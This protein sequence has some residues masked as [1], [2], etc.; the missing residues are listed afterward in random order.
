MSLVILPTS[1]II[2][3]LEQFDDMFSFY[4]S[5]IRGVVRDNILQSDLSDI[6]EAQVLR[7][8]SI[9]PWIRKLNDRIVFEYSNS[10]QAIRQ[11]YLEN[12]SDELYVEMIAEYANALVFEMLNTVFMKN[13]LNILSYKWAYIDGKWTRV[14]AW[15]WVGNDLLVQVEHHKDLNNERKPVSPA[16]H[17]P[18]TER[19]YFRHR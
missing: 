11:H 12:T 3:E 17:H 19:G 7:T 1:E 16:G 18:V 6:S 5:G 15:R 9:P 10:Y 4:D 2:R 14:D 8:N 13:N